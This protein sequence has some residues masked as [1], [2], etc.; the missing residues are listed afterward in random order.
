[1]RGLRSVVGVWIACSAALIGCPERSETER[2]A[3]ACSGGSAN[4]CGQLAD[5]YR[6]GDGVERDPTRAFALYEQ[7]C[8]GGDYG[9]CFSVAMAHRRGSGTALDVGQAMKLL[10]E[11]C[12]RGEEIS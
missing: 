5:R 11:Q 4:A 2:L 6:N 1:M 12:T 8:K 7:S 3:R 10:E 9:G